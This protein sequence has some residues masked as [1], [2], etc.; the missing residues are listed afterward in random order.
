MTRHSDTAETLGQRLEALRVKNGEPSFAKLSQRLYLT[1]GEYTP[2][3]ETLRRLHRGDPRTASPERVDLV[4]LCALVDHYGAK[5]RDVSEIAA[6]RGLTIR[7]TM[8]NTFY[9]SA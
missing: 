9:V 7:E 3:A 1:L 6:A 8:A 5:V 4:L 2:T